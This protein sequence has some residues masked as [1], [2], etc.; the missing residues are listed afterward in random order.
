MLGLPIAQQ[1]CVRFT[2]N[3]AGHPKVG[4]LENEH[5]RNEE[6][7]TFNIAVHNTIILQICQSTHHL[8]RQEA[9]LLVIEGITRVNEAAQ[10]VLLKQNSTSASH[11]TPNNKRVLNSHLYILEDQESIAGT[12]SRQNTR[13]IFQ[14]FRFYITV[15]NHTYE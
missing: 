13:I 3:L 11:K 7:C 2:W 10:V 9:A 5:I 8:Q 6:V 4:Q 12:F 15:Y 14:S 1:N